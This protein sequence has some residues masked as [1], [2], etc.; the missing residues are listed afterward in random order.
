MY[1]YNI[2]SNE[3][4]YNIFYIHIIYI[5]YNLIDNCR[6]RR[7]MIAARVCDECVNKPFLNSI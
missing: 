6:A 4:T 2:F 1:T 7:I 3:E 5:I